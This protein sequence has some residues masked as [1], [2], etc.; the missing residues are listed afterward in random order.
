MKTSGQCS[1]IA[2]IKK[3]RE[4]VEETQAAESGEGGEQG[5]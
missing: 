2:Q 1:R 3:Q 4:P 5:C